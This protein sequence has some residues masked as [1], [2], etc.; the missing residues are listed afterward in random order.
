M[1]SLL[2]WLVALLLLA[3]M[4]AVAQTVVTVGV[5][6]LDY[7]PM[8]AVRDGQYV[9]AAREI[10]DGFAAANG[11]RIEYRPLP[12]KR[13]YAALAAGE[14]M[15]KFPDSPDWQG[16]RAEGPTYSFSTEV[17]AAID[18]VMVL[19]ARRGQP[20]DSLRV[21]GTVEGFTPRAWSQRIARGAVT[22]K[23][24]PRLELLL[25]QVAADRLD[26]AYANVAVAAHTL[27]ESL[28]T[29]DAL[30]YDPALPHARE[31]Y[32]LSTA[33]RPDLVIALDAWLRDNERTVRAIKQRYGVEPPAE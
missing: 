26:G 30:V 32:R 21:L 6:E 24:T 2:N 29:P 9:G 31:S 19:P 8:Y 27:R 1:R 5:E 16:A 15:A 33:S 4:P 17:L 23:E 25:R 20:A 22:L 18:G 12:V 14:V 7:Y 3:A 10:F 11:Y 13:L 28:L